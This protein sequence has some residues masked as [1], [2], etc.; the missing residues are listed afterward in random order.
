M[1][2]LKTG[3][4]NTK[5]NDLPEDSGKTNNN[6]SLVPSEEKKPSINLDLSKD[7]LAVIEDFR[8][9]SYNE[10]PDVGL[11]LEQTGKYINEF[12]KPLLKTEL[13]VSMISNYVKKKIIESPVKKQYYRSHIADLIIIAVAKPILTLENIRL[14]IEV[15]KDMR[16]SREMYETF[17]SI[18]EDTLKRTF[19]LEEEDKRKKDEDN[20]ITIMRYIST[21][22]SYKIFL[23]RCFEIE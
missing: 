8:F 16:S 9:P 12:L 19:R 23:D 21:A 5:K 1:D 14:M 11:F 10:I 7:E 2:L 13:T 4:T 3:R 20:P 17:C 18:F 15:E 22:V 6:I